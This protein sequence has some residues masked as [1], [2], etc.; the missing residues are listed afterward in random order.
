MKNKFKYANRCKSHWLIGNSVM[1]T[2]ANSGHEVY[3]ISP[4][5]VK[6]PIINYHDI[7]IEY[8]DDAALIDMFETRYWPGYKLI[9]LLSESGD[10]MSNFTLSHPN[11][12]KLLK[13]GETFDAVIVEIFWVEALYGLA[14][15]FNCP[16]IGLSTFSTSI[17]TNDLTQ[18]PMEYSY[19]P[20]NFAKLSENMNFAQ[21]T[22][23]LLTSQYEN[24]F[25]ALVHYR[26]QV[27]LI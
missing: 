17:W 5:P 9:N 22:Y 26:R 1:S 14:A 20:H 27:S 12:Q 4:F 24:L 23:N 2:L 8:P 6:T 13:S 3:V 19:V 11:V 15:H 25:R 10:M 18:V 7:H 21:R 16:L